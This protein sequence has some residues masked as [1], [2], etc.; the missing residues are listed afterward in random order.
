MTTIRSSILRLNEKAERI[1][2][3]IGIT[4]DR[5]LEIYRSVK[6]VFIKNNVPWCK[7]LS[8]IQKDYDKIDEFAFALIVF[9]YYLGRSKK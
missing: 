8:V 4:H 9:G 6:N 1:D 2:D 3:T 5:G 7:V